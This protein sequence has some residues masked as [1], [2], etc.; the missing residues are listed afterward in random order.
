MD[1]NKGNQVFKTSHSFKALVCLI[2]P[3][4]WLPTY[5][6][7]QIIS[8]N[9]YLVISI[10]ITLSVFLIFTYPF[11]RRRIE[12]GENAIIIVKAFTTR[13][14]PYSSLRTVYLKK[15]FG[16]YAAPQ[17]SL[18]IFELLTSWMLASR[19]K[20]FQYH[21]IFEYEEADKLKYL[22]V[23]LTPIANR[24]ELIGNLG[25]KFQLEDYNKSKWGGNQ[26]KFY[27]SFFFIVSIIILVVF[28][29]SKLR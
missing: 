27:I 11:F 10:L 29:L 6:I 23:N 20:N 18:F 4:I 28:L 25:K 1:E 17:D 19:N 9:Y 26:R 5:I 22:S 24:E 8:A 13:S 7:S 3:F 21:L 12:I 16:S 2:L 15:Q 14:L